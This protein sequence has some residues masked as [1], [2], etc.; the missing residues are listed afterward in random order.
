MDK[1]CYGRRLDTFFSWSHSAS[2]IYFDFDG[3]VV[4]F[5]NFIA[6]FTKVWHTQ[7]TSIQT[8]RSRNTITFACGSCSPHDR[9]NDKKGILTLL[10]LSRSDHSFVVHENQ[11]DFVTDIKSIVTQMR[12]KQ[13]AL[14]MRKHR[15]EI[16]ISART[17]SAST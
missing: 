12:Y 9:L 17:V 11:T 6:D 14:F 7:P 15:L 4:L 2:L 1:V 8:A 3:R 10:M 16:M 13:L 5:S